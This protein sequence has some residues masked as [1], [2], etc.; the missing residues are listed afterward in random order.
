[1]TCVICVPK[2]T[3]FVLRFEYKDDL[4]YFDGRTEW[5]VEPKLLDEKNWDLKRNCEIAGF[6]FKKKE[7]RKKQDFL[8]L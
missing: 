3:G 2:K 1:M 8:H 4:H 6:L 5:L 7:M